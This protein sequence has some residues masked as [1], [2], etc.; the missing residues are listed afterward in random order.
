[1]P[2]LGFFYSLFVYHRRGIGDLYSHSVDAGMSPALFVGTQGVHD[3]EIGPGSWSSEG[4]YGYL[5][6]SWKFWDTGLYIFGC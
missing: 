6:V 1:M 2:F 5:A 3:A 4:R